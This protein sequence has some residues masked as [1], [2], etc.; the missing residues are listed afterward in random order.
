MVDR[1]SCVG[2][3]GVPREVSSITDRY[4]SDSEVF[5]IWR[6]FRLRLRL[7]YPMASS[8]YSELV[9]YDLADELS[10]PTPL[11]SAPEAVSAATVRLSDETGISALDTLA[12]EITGA[13]RL[14]DT[15]DLPS[16]S[17]VVTAAQ[18]T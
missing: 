2:V 17:M 13:S 4:S 16:T 11:T 8:D 9:D 1:R 3:N 6:P 12:D 5:S 10:Q 15:N 18:L 14:S 7:G